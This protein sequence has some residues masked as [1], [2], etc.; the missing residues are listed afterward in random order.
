MSRAVAVL[1]R[2]EE[3][4]LLVPGWPG[5]AWLAAYCGEERR[6]EAYPD[7]A[8]AAAALSGCLV[9]PPLPGTGAAALAA[10]EEVAVIRHL[11]ALPGLAGEA[12]E[13]LA[14]RGEAPEA[15]GDGPPP[16]EIEWD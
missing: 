6:W 4:G 9:W 10:E 7:E 5:G 12:A 1:L 14:R 8:A 13:R 15:P 2:P 11:A 3:A 16:G